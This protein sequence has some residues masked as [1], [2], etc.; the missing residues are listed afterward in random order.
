MSDSTIS[1]Y[2]S[3]LSYTQGP[4]VSLAMIILF[5]PSSFQQK[6]NSNVG[7]AGVLNI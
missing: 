5:S 3:A 7:V 1:T 2:F 4:Q 6:K